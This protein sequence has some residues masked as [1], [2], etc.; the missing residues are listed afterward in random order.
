HSQ[1]LLGDPGQLLLSAIY[2]IH[3]YT[4]RS[5][6]SAQRTKVFGDRARVLSLYAPGPPISLL[7][8]FSKIF[9]RAIKTRLLKY[10]EENTILP[11][12][13]YGFRE[14]TG[15]EDAL[16]QLSRNLYSNMEKK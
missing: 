12:S 14:N 1:V 15:T 2:I 7:N 13:Q 3:T 10:L 4:G 11:S 6:C 5:V 9:E 8:V 16:V